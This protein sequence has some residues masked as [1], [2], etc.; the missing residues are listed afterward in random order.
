ML[1]SAAAAEA[2]E[3]VQTI[4]GEIRTFVVVMVDEESAEDDED[5]LESLESVDESSLDKSEKMGTDYMYI[6][7]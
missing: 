1:V 6:L 2:G 7:I 5:R 3:A 4:F